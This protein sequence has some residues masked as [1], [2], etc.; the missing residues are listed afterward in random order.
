MKKLIR[1]KSRLAGLLI[2]SLV[3]GNLVCMPVST[4]HG[5]ETGDAVV[6]EHNTGE[7]SEDAAEAETTGSPEEAENTD[8]APEEENKEELTP[9]A[10]PT[11]EPEKEVTPS[12]EPTKEPELEVTPSVKPTKEPEEEVTPSAEPTKEPEEE[13]T[14]SVEPTKEP[15]KEPEEEV[16]P[17]AE[18]T[19]EPEKEV[20]PSAKPTKEPELEV[21]PS[22]EPTKEPEEEPTPSPTP[23]IKPSLQL[24]TES[25]DARYQYLF[26]TDVVELTIDNPPE[27][28]ATE[29]EAAA[30]MT[31]ITVPV[32]K[33]GADGERYASKFKLTIH[34]KLAKNVKAIFK[35]IYALDMKFPIRVLKGYGYRKVG[36]VGLSNSTLI[37]MHAFG[38]AIDINP[39]DYDNDYYL[40]KGNDLRDKSNPYCIPDEVIEIFER[41]GWFWGGNFEICADTMHFQYLGLEYLTYQGNSP[42]R[43]LKVKKSY[44]KG[45]DIKNLQQ[46]LS[47]LGYKVAIDGVY[48]NRTASAV[49]KYQ[50]QSGLK[51]TGVVDYKTWETLINETHYM[52]YAF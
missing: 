35:E 40:G 6:A 45:I 24:P 27:G 12:A 8:P 32:W 26:G 19:K 2:F 23:T 48:G 39:W 37:S 42:F 28:F 4:V 31:T 3:I 38:A 43:D 51:A 15:T 1:N 10:E 41:Y 50:K 17:S 33:I 29:Q 52:P 11:K 7:A 25:N 36:G 14:P 46:R 44:M 13:V 49:K 20:T 18:P 30:Q 34:K 47:E 21:T 16:T 5:Y 9:S 22:A